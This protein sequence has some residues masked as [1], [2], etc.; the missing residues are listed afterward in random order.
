MIRTVPAQT[1]PR[2][3][4]TR[5]SW[6][7]LAKL[8]TVDHLRGGGIAVEMSETATPTDLE[9]PAQAIA[10]MAETL[11]LNA[12]PASVVTRAKLHILDALGL[13][14]ASTVQEFG[15]RAVAGLIAISAADGT[16]A[17]C[18]VIG[19][20]P[21]LAMRDAAMAN[22]ILI[23][24]LDFDDTHLGSIIH[25]TCT[26]LPAALSL[27]EALGA[28]GEQVLTAFLAGA[29]TGIR[30][31]L[32]VDGGFHHVGFHATGVVSHFA[33]AVTAGKLL[34]LDAA[35]ITAAQGITGSTA[36]GIQVFL[37]EGA[38][39]KRLHPGWGAVA[40]I[41][42]A[43]LARSGFKGPTRP[44]EGKFGLF[45]THLHSEARLAE[46]TRDLGTLWHFDQTALKPYPVC[47]F[48]H[49]CADAAIDLHHEIAGAQIA[50]V[51]A[52]LPEATLHIIAEPAEAK[53]RPGSDYEAKFSA[54]FVTAYCLLYGR[55]N[56]PDLEP[57]ALADSAALALALHVKCHADPDSAF[58]TYFSGGVEVTLSDGRVLSRY[59]R[60]N[61]G[62]GERAMSADAVTAKFM[63]SASL[64]ISA[65]QAE[66]IR[67]AV[68]SL[69][70]MPVAELMA[71]LR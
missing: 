55:F 20:A 71:L 35:Q 10:R 49:G 47:H 16:S 2:T 38:W 43:Y 57:A 58:P 4:P 59:V 15:R 28:S 34:G 17:V 8:S 41:T 3:F 32:A 40:G 62:A 11:T 29:E 18:S 25:P 39:T 51:R 70:D 54:Q 30:I 22:G 36:S 63:A 46:L 48:I 13:G 56:L 60:V 42:A 6:A 69:E 61:S 45:A 64:A 37:E 68:L 27:G 26:A 19:N 23:H 33:S 12:I 14:L 21:R 65:S 52:F 1:T 44:Y 5:I 53:E 31:G 9:T 67:D 24:G 50:S 7:E 66:R